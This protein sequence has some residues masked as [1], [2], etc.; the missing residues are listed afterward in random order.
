MFSTGQCSL[1]PSST[2]RHFC[3]NYYRP[4]QLCWSALKAESKENPQV[5]S[6][7]QQV[8]HLN[9]LQTSDRLGHPTKNTPI[10][11]LP[12]MYWHWEGS[13]KGK[14]PNY[15]HVTWAPAQPGCKAREEEGTTSGNLWAA[16]PAV[17]SHR[18][19]LWQWKIPPSI[20]HTLYQL[21]NNMW[22]KTTQL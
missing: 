17:S 20:Q 4:T 16:S 18:Q 2:G 22:G 3:K 19:K 13:D 11:E 1:V 5:N 10:Q 14:H 12:P 15:K 7:S 6:R 8:E 9:F 21:C